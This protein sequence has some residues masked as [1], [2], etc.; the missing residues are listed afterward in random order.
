MEKWWRKLMRKNFKSLLWISICCTATAFAGNSSVNWSYTGN[1]GPANWGNLDTSFSSC[2]SGKTQSPID[3]VKPILPAT[4]DLSIKYQSAPL[5]IVNDG[6]TSLMINHKPVIIHQGHAIQLNFAENGTKESI[7]FKGK[8]YRLKEFHFH[9]PGETAIDGKISP[10]EIHFVHQSE[11]EQVAVLAV[12]VNE[13]EANQELAGIIK[14]IPK[15]HGVSHE[16]TNRTVNPVNLMPQKK[17]Y[18]YFAGS[19]TTPPCTEGLH[20]I[21]MP[22][23]ITA[24]KEQIDAFKTAVGGDN[25]RP[26]Q[27]GNQRNIYYSV[28]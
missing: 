1:G 13:G 18:Y 3:I 25:A 24:S 17:N 4:Y 2:N 10:M 20:W 7:I 5:I 28:E 22:D 6:E 12:L 19:L 14:D 9:T 8:A 11:D 26:L 27:P 23:T 15:D 16:V 21:V